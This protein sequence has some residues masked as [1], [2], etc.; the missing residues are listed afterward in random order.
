MPP[1]QV[2]ARILTAA[3]F[4]FSLNGCVN[5]DDVAGLSKLSDEARVALPKVSND[6]GATCIRQNML[7][8]NTPAAELPAN[9]K[10]LRCETYQELA[11]HLARDQ[12][13][14]LDYFDALG[15]LSSNRP[16]SYGAAIDSNTSALSTNTTL[17]AS[18][19]KAGTDAQNILK[20]LADAGTRGYRERQLGDLM[21]ANDPAIQSLTQALKKIITDDYGV[22]LSNEESA[23]DSFYQGPMAAAQP[24]ERLALILVQRQYAN[25]KTTLQSHK[26][27]ILLYAKLMDGLGTLH[28]KLTRQAMEKASP[29][30]ISKQVGPIV[31]S[32]KVAISD[33]STR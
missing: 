22:M 29:A 27:E 17:S 23:V 30:E 19:I 3:F 10:A 13:V 5:L 2:S 24:S 21:K 9:L 25:D 6:I 1:N 31:E 16:L 32:L 18:A 15:K 8:E 4:L 20:S 11:S 28:A 26:D 33:L 7:L 12:N 14:L